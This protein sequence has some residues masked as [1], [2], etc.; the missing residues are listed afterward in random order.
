MHTRN[1]NYQRN[2]MLAMAAY[3]VVVL[4]VWPMARTTPQF[5]LKVLYALTPML[6][7][8]YA[9]WLMARKIWYSDELE[10]RTHLVGLGFATIVVSIFSM[11]G[12]FLANAKVLSLDACA[13]LLLW[14]FPVLMMSYGIGQ[15]WV[16]RQYGLQ[17][18]CDDDDA[19]PAYQRLLS[20]GA[21]GGVVS[22][23]AW[24]KPIDN[25]RFG[26]LIGISGGLGAVGLLLGLRRW[27]RRDEPHQ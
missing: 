14:V 16:R 6:P 9:I 1:K 10:Q 22:V 13:E 19:F 21:L 26:L 2:F 15:I 23:W 17:G 20:A 25:F 12:G 8:S 11:V 24:F 18:M 3:V 4:V 7:L 27:L 5:F